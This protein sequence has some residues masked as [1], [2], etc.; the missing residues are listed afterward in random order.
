M[1]ERSPM[2]DEEA[3][4]A[5]NEAFY[6]AFATHD[7]A[8]MDALWSKRDA[9]GLHSS[10]LERPA[11]ARGMVMESWTAILT[12]PGVAA[13]PLGGAARVRVSARAPT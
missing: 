6:R 5:V 10:R 11:R 13:D 12:A 9:R 7:V 2:S 1:P 3:V 8:A 4:L